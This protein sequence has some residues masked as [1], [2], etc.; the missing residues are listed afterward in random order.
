M[1]NDVNMS[2]LSL[3]TK[4][5][6]LKDELH[7][8]DALY[9][10]L[11]KDPLLY[12]L[13]IHKRALENP[14]Q[15]W[16]QEQRSFNNGVKTLKIAQHSEKPLHKETS[17]RI[18]FITTYM[19][20]QVVEINT[21]AINLKEINKIIL[22]C[23]DQLINFKLTLTNWDESS[24]S[25]LKDIFV[26]LTQAYNL[27]QISFNSKYH[28]SASSLQPFS[29]K[30]TY[31]VHT[32]DF[33]LCRSGNLITDILAFFPKA[34][35]IYLPNTNSNPVFNHKT[36]TKLATVG[37][38][39]FTLDIADHLKTIQF[40]KEDPVLPKLPNLNTLIVKNFKIEN[41]A[42][43]MQVNNPEKVAFKFITIEQVCPIAAQFPTIKKLAFK[44]IPKTK[45]EMSTI[46]ID[47]TNTDILMLVYPN[48]ND[49]INLFEVQ[50]K[51]IKTFTYIPINFNTQNIIKNLN[52]Q[53]NEP[54]N[55]EGPSSSK[56]QR[57]TNASI[58]IN[59]KTTAFKDILEEANETFNE[60]EMLAA[61]EDFFRDL[62]P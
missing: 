16:M 55:P 34:K 25:D 23:F 22:T 30:T 20:P 2:K 57:T 46:V 15:A 21:A 35:T 36:L 27:K 43:F 60:K 3:L 49:F 39:I 5:F 9:R 52:N 45:K 28:H 56:R 58:E 10:T 47:L 41:L 17:E 59:E 26:S 1:T 7:L 62:E 12:N 40:P 8:Q 32:I 31:D 61:V 42:K 19:K 50:E 24:S 14:E 48:T 33:N 6:N 18:Q 44:Y 13:Q 51:P 4:G 54:H 38:N 11:E 29:P 53:S 37:K